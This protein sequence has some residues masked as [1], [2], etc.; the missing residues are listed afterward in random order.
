MYVFTLS[1]PFMSGWTYRFYSVNPILTMRFALSLKR[2]ADSG[3]QQEWRSTQ[4][5]SSGL[6]GGVLSAVHVS[7][8]REGIEMGPV[9]PQKG[10]LQTP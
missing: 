9:G 8:A 5:T 2:S 3:A 6:G 4:V 10:R 1:S 7:S